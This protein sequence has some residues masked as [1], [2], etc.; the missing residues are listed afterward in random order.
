MIKINKELTRPDGGNVS[1]G[2]II[3][4]TPRFLNEIMVASFDLRHFV[5]VQTLLDG[6]KT[7]PSVI[8]FKYRLNKQC[9][10][11]QW[12]LLNNAGSADLVQEW[13]KDLI[14]QEIGAGFTEIISYE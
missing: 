4:Y 7:I 1:T 3:E 12:E 6:K 14:D 10:A 8:E 9:D 5:S 2:S 13:L 11:E